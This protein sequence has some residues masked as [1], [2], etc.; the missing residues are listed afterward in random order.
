MNPISVSSPSLISPADNITIE[1]GSKL[2]YQWQSVANATSYEIL[3]LFNPG[4]ELTNGNRVTVTGTTYSDEL[5]HT[6]GLYSWEVMAKTEGGLT[7]AANRRYFSVAPHNPGNLQ[8]T[9]TGCQTT[10]LTWQDNSAYE[11]A[12]YAYRNGAKINEQAALNGGSGQYQDSGLAEKT[13]YEYKVVAHHPAASLAGVTISVETP[14]CP[15]ALQYTLSTLSSGNGSV[16]ISKP[17]PY[18]SGTQIQLTAV[19]DSGWRFVRWESTES[20]GDQTNLATITVTVS[21]DATYTAYFEPDEEPN[22]E[23]K[24]YLPLINR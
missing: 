23:T 21:K 20:L 11:T 19:P 13:V 22:D 9:A 2:T 16:T 10:T 1:E 7:S 4:G 3:Q 17:G 24:V 6:P 12:Y 8:V 18:P 15:V 5:G 14:S